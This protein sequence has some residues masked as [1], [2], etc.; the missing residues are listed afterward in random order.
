MVQFESE[1]IPYYLQ[2]LN[3]LREAGICCELYPEAVKMKKQF[4]YADAKKIAY[5]LLAGEDEI[6]QE[7]YTLKHLGSGQQQLVSF[8]ELLDILQNNR[9][10]AL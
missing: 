3:L 1:S 5:V 4:S 8:Q 6:K 7:K 2:T 10:L 9:G